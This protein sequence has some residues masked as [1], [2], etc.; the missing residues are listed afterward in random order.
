MFVNDEVFIAQARQVA[1]CVLEHAMELSLAPQS[2][3][4]SPYLGAVVTF[5]K[6]VCDNNDSPIQAAVTR[7]IALSSSL[8]V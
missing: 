6:N 1:F 5:A 3:I 7:I 8:T 4:I 2:P